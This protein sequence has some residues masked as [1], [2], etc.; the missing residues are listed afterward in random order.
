MHCCKLGQQVIPAC[1]AYV[2]VF[3]LQADLSHLGLIKF[4]SPVSATI[5]R[6]S[7][8]WRAAC[9]S[10]ALLGLLLLAANQLG[11]LSLMLLLTHFIW[12]WSK[13][14]LVC[15]E[16]VQHQLR[17]QFLTRL[18]LDC[19]YCVKRSLP[20]MW[21]GSYLEMVMHLEKGFTYCEIENTMRPTASCVT[22]TFG[23][24]LNCFDFRLWTAGLLQVHTAEV[25]NGAFFF[26]FHF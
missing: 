22:I 14:A 12:S 21:G 26:L 1:S 24:K 3:K 17:P 5:S 19:A 6:H 2:H 23:H 7:W 20:E 16:L 25:Q 4:P 18:L 9:C 13:D 15:M 8:C 10:L 11:S